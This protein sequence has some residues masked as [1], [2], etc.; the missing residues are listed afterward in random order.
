M[1][2][3]DALRLLQ[4]QCD[5]ASLATSIPRLHQHTIN[6]TQ[7]ASASI[8]SKTSESQGLLFNATYE[9]I[10]TSATA[11]V[12]ATFG[13]L[14]AISLELWD[15]NDIF[16]AAQ[17]CRYWQ[18][19]IEQSSRLQVRVLIIGPSLPLYDPIELHGRSINNDVSTP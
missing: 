16:S 9:P 19:V 15:L 14:E 8:L 10:L 4:L 5:I 7:A 11:E 3:T 1:E 17:V 18:Q 2:R 6:E 12:F 13:L